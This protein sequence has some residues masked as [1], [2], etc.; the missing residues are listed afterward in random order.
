MKAS[1]L[2]Y[3]AEYR[4]QGLDADSSL[5]YFGQEGKKFWFADAGGNAKGKFWMS[6]KQVET[7]ITGKI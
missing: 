2:E 6:E 4:H 3:K 1:E 5:V 7:L